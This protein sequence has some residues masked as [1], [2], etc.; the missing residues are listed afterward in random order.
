MV[1]MWY[2]YSIPA[3]FELQKRIVKQLREWIRDLESR[4]LIEGFAF[5]HYFNNIQR[6]DVLC[7]RFDYRDEDD[8]VKVEQELAVKA[9]E[10]VPTYE[11]KVG[12]WESPNEGELEAYELGS[13]CALLFWDLVDKGRLKEEYVADFTK[14]DQ[15]APLVFQ[16]CFIHGLMNSLGVTTLNELN[17]HLNLL[18]NC[19]KTKNIAELRK[20]LKP[21]SKAK[22]K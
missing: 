4:K 12:R 6:G 16:Q 20:W 18:M 8:R 5:D 15:Q 10:L 2:E 14:S 1:I 7:I 22:V 11:L 21:I 17:I 19:T 9:K 13:R 3:D